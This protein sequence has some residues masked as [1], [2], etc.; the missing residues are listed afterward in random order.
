LRAELLGG[1]RAELLAEF[2]SLETQTGSLQT[3]LQQVSASAD[4]ARATLAEMERRQREEIERRWWR[5]VPGLW[6]R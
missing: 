3:T 5:R 2:R 6:R 4:A 1:L